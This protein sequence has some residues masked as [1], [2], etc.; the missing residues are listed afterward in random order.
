MVGSADYKV[1]GDGLLAVRDLQDNGQSN[2]GPTPPAPTGGGID[3]IVL[4]SSVI[5]TAHYSGTKTAFTSLISTAAL[6][7]LNYLAIKGTG[8]AEVLL[9]VQGVARI[10]QWDSYWVS[11]HSFDYNTV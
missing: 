11:I 8:S 10:P 7:E 1:L 3:T 5:R 2:S 6:M 4:D 9:K